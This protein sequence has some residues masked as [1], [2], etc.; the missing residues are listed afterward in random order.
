[1]IQPADMKR[2]ASDA[3]VCALTE[4][5][6]AL[7]AYC[8]A[9]LGHCEEAKDTWQ[10]TNLVLWRK[11]GD[12]DPQ[13]KFLRWALA[14]AR[15]EVLASIRDR[16][17]D[18]LVFDDDVVQ[19]MADSSLEVAEAHESRREALAGCTEKLQAHH[20]EVLTAHYVFGHTLVEIAAS[21]GLSL[22][23][24]KVLLMRLRRTLAQ[25]IERQLKQE[26]AT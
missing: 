8:A 7:R 11:A 26:S 15:F 9:A 19:L 12:W 24:V 16:Q 21:R 13:T 3:F 1:M 22:S 17:R 5:Q 14:V 20:R 23:A 4:A 25:C 18:R 2:P 10:R 6:P